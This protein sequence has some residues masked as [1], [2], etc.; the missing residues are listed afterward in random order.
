MQLV[1]DGLIDSR[2]QD[3]WERLNVLV[4]V[5]VEMAEQDYYGAYTFGFSATVFVNPKRICSASFTH[6]LLHVRLK[7]EGLMANTIFKTAIIKSSKL[8]RIIPPQAVEHITN[9]LDHIKMLPEYLKL[10]YNKEDFIIDFQESKLTL[11]DAKMIAESI[12]ARGNQRLKDIGAHF[13]IAK[14]FG[15]LACPNNGIDYSKQLQFL[16]NA[17]KALYEIMMTF[18]AKWKEWDISENYLT[19]DIENETSH[20]ERLVVDFLTRIEKWME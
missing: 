13:F 2:N 10:G 8:H 6:E 12:Q 4:P 14:L 19:G 20:E 18:N 3:L 11:E 17:D 16:Q 7:R 1:P 5:K 15:V 9:C